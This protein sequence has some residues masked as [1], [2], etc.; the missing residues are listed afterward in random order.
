ME[1]GI[2][3]QALVAGVAQHRQGFLEAS[4]LLV[5]SCY[6]RSFFA[7]WMVIFRCLIL[8]SVMLQWFARVASAIGWPFS[9]FWVFVWQTDKYLNGMKCFLIYL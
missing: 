1:W 7:S 9:G 2:E 6:C 4:N 8:S 5:P 3:L